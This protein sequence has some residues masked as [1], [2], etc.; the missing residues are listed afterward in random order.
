LSEPPPSFSLQ[1]LSQSPTV[2]KQDLLT[3]LVSPLSR[4]SKLALALDRLLKITPLG[5]DDSLGLPVVL[6]QIRGMLRAVQPGVDAASNKVRAWQV[7]RQL[8]FR[9]G[10]R[11]DL[12]LELESD[13]RALLKIGRIHRRQRTER[14]WHGWTELCLVLFDNYLLI[15]KE[16]MGAGGGQAGDE[17]DRVYAV[18][19][20][21][22]LPTPSL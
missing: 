12:T 8:R 3:F 13:E 9:R 7:A 10:E 20:R 16:E 21:V 19:S 14:D 22:R 18:V 11:N 1:R 6:D 5:S 4:L 2:R 17:E 15:T